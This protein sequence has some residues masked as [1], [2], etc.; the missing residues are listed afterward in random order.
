[1]LCAIWYFKCFVNG[2]SVCWPFA[3]PIYTGLATRSMRKEVYHCSK[4]LRFCQHFLKSQGVT[5][6]NEY[7]NKE[8]SA[9]C[10]N[11]AKNDFTH[12]K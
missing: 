3:D 1:M 10:I 6:E 11:I 9:V 7:S 8:M 4:K 5:G 12:M 2:V